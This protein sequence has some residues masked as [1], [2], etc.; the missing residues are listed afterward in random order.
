MSSKFE[1]IAAMDYVDR[2]LLVQAVYLLGLFRAAFLLIPFRRLMSS[3]E[4]CRESVALVPVTPEQSDAAVRIGQLVATAARYTPW[5]SRCLVQ[6][7]VTQRLLARR[8]I[9]GQFYLGVRK[10]CETSGDPTGFAAHAWLQC[11]DQIVNGAAGHEHFKILSTY[12][13]GA[14]ETHQCLNT[15]G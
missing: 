7:L 5:Q 10:G 15:S 6:V 2:R 9:A 3:L 12:R 11:G 13:W 4:L 14:L 8:G 1:K